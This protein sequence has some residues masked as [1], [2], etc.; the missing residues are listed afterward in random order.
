MSS[1]MSYAIEFVASTSAAPA[2]RI[3]RRYVAE[4]AD[5]D[6]AEEYGVA[7]MRSLNP[8]DDADGFRI[9]A[10]GILKRAVG[11]GSPAWDGDAPVASRSHPGGRKA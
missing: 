8:A 4:F 6:A 9:Y 5:V 7:H 10:G 2:G 11:A 1:I 3:I